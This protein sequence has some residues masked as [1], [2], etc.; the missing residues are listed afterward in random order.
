DL[1]TSE[2]L[3]KVFEYIHDINSGIDKELFSR[4]ELLDITAYFYKVNHLLEVLNFEKPNLELED[5]EIE[6]LIHERSEAKKQ[7]NY[8]RADEIRNLL[9]EKGILLEDTKTGVKWKRK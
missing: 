6:R 9:F 3:A 7:K 1:N 2:A 8:A 5:E 4:D